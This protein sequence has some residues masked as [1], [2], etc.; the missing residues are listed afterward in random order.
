MD[1]AQDGAGRLVEH[2]NNVAASSW[3]A[4]AGPDISLLLVFFLSSSLIDLQ[5]RHFLI[6]I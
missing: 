1:T 6:Y 3:P 2:A 5:A 4:V